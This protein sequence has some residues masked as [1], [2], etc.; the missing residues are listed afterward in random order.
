MDLP[1]VE[2]PNVHKDTELPSH[3]PPV[4]VVSPCSNELCSIPLTLKGMVKLCA[5]YLGALK[6]QLSDVHPATSS[7]DEAWVSIST[8]ASLQPVQETSL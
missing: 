6:T 4:L 5:V 3:Q 8:S 7:M 1:K 2:L